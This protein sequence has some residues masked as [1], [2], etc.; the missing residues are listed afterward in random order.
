MVLQE[1]RAVKA[2]WIAN[3]RQPLVPMRMFRALGESSEVGVDSDTQEGD[4]RLGGKN[5]EVADTTG[6][7]LRSRVRTLCDRALLACRRCKDASLARLANFRRDSYQND[8]AHDPGESDKAPLDSEEVSGLLDIAACDL[9]KP[10]HSRQA[11]EGAAADSAGVAAR[12][13]VT[14][15]ESRRLV[16]AT[17]VI[18]CI[19]LVARI[20][21]ADFLSQPP[22]DPCKDVDCGAH[23]S[24]FG[25]NCV[26][27]A[28][29]SGEHCET[30]PCHGVDCGR[31]GTCTM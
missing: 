1:A 18:I 16:V 21:L 14:S 11:D 23:G 28:G 22:E 26:C 25:G 2:A 9:D 12:L 29:Y 27:S 3:D 6:E 30:H 8:A 17:V 15:A 4:G 5:L 10:P 13:M 31:H 19:V 20:V 7:E 24:C